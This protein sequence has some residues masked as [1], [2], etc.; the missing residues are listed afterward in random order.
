V[1]ID[2]TLHA[3]AAPVLWLTV[4]RAAAGGRACRDYV[5]YG[6]DGSRLLTA[7]AFPW[8]R[9]IPLQFAPNFDRALLT[10]RRRRS[11]PFSGKVDVHELP[12]SRRIGV[13]SRSGRY[14]DAHG[15]IAGAFRD[16]RTFRDHAKEGAFLAVM[17]ALL[18]GDGTDSSASGPSG[19]IHLVANRPAG[20]LSRAR[21]PFA[22]T[23]TRTTPKRTNPLRALLPRRLGDALFE[24]T[25]SRGWKLERTVPQ[26]AEDPR[27]YVAAA[28]FAVEL[29]HW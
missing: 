21:L 6:D 22:I 20:T 15:K 11:F 18:G 26:A 27:L 7:R 5:I 13:V 29:S 3:L 10:L 14:R 12:G 23:P 25:A 4:Q 17:Q 24:R 2:S 16:A 19:F 28:L 9:D 8:R 1:T